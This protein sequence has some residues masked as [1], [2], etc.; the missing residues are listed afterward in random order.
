MIDIFPSN[1][2][3]AL[4]LPA[5]FYQKCHA[6]AFGRCDHQ[7]VNNPIL[8]CTVEFITNAHN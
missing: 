5:R 3:P 1:I 4:L 6:A 7:W 8:Y 2:F